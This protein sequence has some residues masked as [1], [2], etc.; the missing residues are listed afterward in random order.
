MNNELAGAYCGSSPGHFDTHIAPHI[1][2]IKLGRSVRYDKH[3]IDKFIDSKQQRAAGYV[4]AEEALAR[5]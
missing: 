4:S 5:L 2:K 3:E 1:T